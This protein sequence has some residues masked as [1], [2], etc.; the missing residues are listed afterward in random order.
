MSS[1]T[2]RRCC[3][4]RCFSR[5][6]YR[7]PGRRGVPPGAGRRT[8]SAMTTRADPACGRGRD[9][10]SRRQP[11]ARHCRGHRVATARDGTLRR[12]RR[13]RRDRCRGRAGGA[14]WPAVPGPGRHPGSAGMLSSDAS[15]T[16][17]R[18]N[19]ASATFSGST[20]ETNEPTCGKTCTR[21]SSDSR[22]RLSR[23][24]VRLTPSA[25][26]SSFSDSALPGG[27][28]SVSILVRSVSYTMRRLVRCC[29]GLPIPA[30]LVDRADMPGWHTSSAT[31][32]FIDRLRRSG[33]SQSAFGM[34]SDEPAPRRCIE[35]AAAMRFVPDR[36]WPIRCRA[37]KC[38]GGTTILGTPYLQ[39]PL[40]ARSDS[41][42]DWPSELPRSPGAPAEPTEF[43]PLQVLHT[44]PT[45][46]CISVLNISVDREPDRPREWD[47]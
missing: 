46:A 13:T 40:R 14:D 42:A 8:L 37:G 30:M 19:W 45:P 32:L 26:A 9:G 6:R 2:A 1:N 3:R 11:S 39:K 33:V 7:R 15:S 4:I 36:V 34:T 22:M 17:S 21:P 28:S 27:S 12:A 16:A 10:P 18:R 31:P 44:W 23:T 29:A 24:G 5:E 20:R 43:G 25:A 38:S 41:P 35:S 47:L